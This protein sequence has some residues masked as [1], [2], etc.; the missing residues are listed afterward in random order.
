VLRLQESTFRAREGC[1]AIGLQKRLTLR[2][3]LGGGRGGRKDALPRVA[4]NWNVI[5]MDVDSDRIIEQ[6]EERTCSN[7]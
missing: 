6:W 1:A 2:G 5:G 4:R 3:E 7:A